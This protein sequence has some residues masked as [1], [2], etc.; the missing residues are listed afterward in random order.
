M[1]MENDKSLSVTYAIYIKMNWQLLKPSR[2]F[3]KFP[4]T[5]ITEKEWERE[6]KNKETNFIGGKKN[7]L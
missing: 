6:I 5:C 4:M 3:D 2:F 7:F 1:D